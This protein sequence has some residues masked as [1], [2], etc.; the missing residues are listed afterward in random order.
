MENVKREMAHLLIR[1]YLEKES[2]D[3]I[4]GGQIR[5]VLQ[6]LETVFG[7]GIPEL[8]TAGATLLSYLG[9]V[10]ELNFEAARENSIGC[11]YLERGLK[12]RA[13][14]HI[15]NAIEMNPSSYEYLTNR[16]LVYYM[17]GNFEECVKDCEHALAMKPGFVKAVCALAACKLRFEDKEGAEKVLQEALAISPANP[18]LLNNLEA[19][20]SGVPPPRCHTTQVELEHTPIVEE[21]VRML[22]PA[23]PV[24]R[25]ASRTLPK[26][27]VASIVAAWQDKS[28][29]TDPA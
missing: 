2:R 8:G 16:A 23:N 14:D 7:P 26:D 19:I 22:I 21:R 15:C 20:N 29:Y 10:D 11:S 9:F 4:S 13:F 12:S 27:T 18:T 17:N 3:P 24:T 5:G 6:R 25:K 1:E 28:V